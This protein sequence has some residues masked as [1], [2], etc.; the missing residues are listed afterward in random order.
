MMKKKPLSRSI[1]YWYHIKTEYCNDKKKQGFK[2][3]I[4]K[5]QDQ[6]KKIQLAR[7]Q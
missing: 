1:G 2:G 6:N 7:S 3:D 5:L 4:N